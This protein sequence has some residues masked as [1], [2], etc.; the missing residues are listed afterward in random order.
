MPQRPL[1][2]GLYLFVEESFAHGTCGARDGSDGLGGVVGHGG[3][4]FECNWAVQGRT[5]CA[6]GDGQ[7]FDEVLMGAG[8][9]SKRNFDVAGTWQGRHD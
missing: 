7:R 9:S 3:S 6:G 5:R 4:V 2:R 1:S 8:R